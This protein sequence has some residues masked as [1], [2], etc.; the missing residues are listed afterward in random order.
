MSLASSISDQD[1]VRLAHALYREQFRA[2]AYRAFEVVNPGE[3]IEWNWHL[4]C[5]SEH[6]EAV[7][8]GD[9]QRL[10][11][12]MPPRALKSYLCSI[13]FPAWVLG[14]EPHE[15]F[16]V[17]SHTLRPL[18]AKLSNDSRRL[19][20]SE[21]YQSVFPNTRLIKS[22]ETEFYT[23]KNGHRLAF[24]AGQSPTGSGTNYGILDDLNKPDEALSDTIRIKTNEWVDGTFMSRYN[25]YRTSKTIVV[26][27]RVHENDVTGHLLEKGGYHHLKLPA[28]FESKPVIQVSGKTFEPDN[29]T[30]LFPARLPKVILDEKRNDLGDYSYAGQFLQSPVPIGG[31][32]F[33]DTW[34]RYFDVEDFDASTCNVYILCDPANSK[35]KTSDWSA[36][37]VVALSTDNNYYLLDM[38]RDKLNPTERVDMVF[39]LHKKWNAKTNKPPKVGME[40]YGLMTDLHYVEEKQK[41][42]SYRFDIVPLGGKASKPDRIARLI[43]DMQM[44][45]WYFPRKINY[46]DSRGILYEL[47]SEMIKGEMLTFPVSKHDDCIDALSR[48]YD[49]DLFATFPKLVKREHRM[50][51]PQDWTDY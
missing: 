2:F 14:R 15:K 47:V 18:A 36:F 35:K 30:L 40:Q 7:Y 44:G 5:T 1:A 39:K 27:Q 50:P 32:L 16:M 38:V 29:D 4:D 11:I 46:I 12:N 9:I 3:R 6:L 45:R 10:I 17:A 25:D 26:M 13:A 42:D 48:V 33:K 31:G 43:P 37:Q 8:R 41:R 51:A 24:A 23:D 28:E 22:T 49:E 20:E 19:I 34:P 21:W